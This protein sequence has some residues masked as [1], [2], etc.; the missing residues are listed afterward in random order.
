[1]LS[2]LIFLPLVGCLFLTI[3]DKTKHQMIRVFSLFWSMLVLNASF[4]LLLFFDSTISEFQFFETNNWLQ[5]ININIIFGIDG[6]A[7]VM[8]LLTAFLIPTCV[9]LC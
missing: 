7:L 9:L 5:T 1:M 2:F 3:L 6:L 8:I 4:V